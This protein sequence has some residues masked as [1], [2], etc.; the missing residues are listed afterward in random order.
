MKDEMKLRKHGT[1][2]RIIFGIFFTR[3][4]FNHYLFV[5]EGS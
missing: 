2:Q 1:V 5:V 4:I 3:I